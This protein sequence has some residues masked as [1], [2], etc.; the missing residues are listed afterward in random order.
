MGVFNLINDFVGV[1]KSKL[2]E[3]LRDSVRNAKEQRNKLR[4]CARIPSGRLNK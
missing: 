4:N 1:N 2:T 3:G